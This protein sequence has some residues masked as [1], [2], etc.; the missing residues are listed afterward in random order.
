MWPVTPRFHHSAN[1]ANAANAVNQSRISCWHLTTISASSRLAPLLYTGGAPIWGFPDFGYLNPLRPRA[2]YQ[3]LGTQSSNFGPTPLGNSA[4]G[5][6]HQ[7]MIA[8][9][10][11]TVVS[12]IN[13]P[14]YV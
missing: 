11:A 7:V 3:L 5:Q 13:K 6:G 8:T 10:N 12:Y 9:D 14:C 1:A 4:S 2:P